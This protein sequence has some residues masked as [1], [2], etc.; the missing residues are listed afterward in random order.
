MH[1]WNPDLMKTIYPRQRALYIP[2]Y[3]SGA[4]AQH[5]PDQN[6]GLLSLGFGQT[7][8]MAAEMG[9]SE[10][11]QKMLNYA[12]RN[13]RGVWEE[14]SYYSPRNDD[15]TPDEHGNS[16]GVGSWTGNVLIALARLHRGDGF[17]KLYKKPWTPSDL[18]APEITDVDELTMS[19]KQA[20]YDASKKVLIVTISDGPVK[21]KTG[22]FVVRRMPAGHVYGV[23]SDGVVDLSASVQKKPDGS[24][25]VSTSLDKSH[26]FVILSE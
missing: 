22:S 7:A 16:H 12:D 18:Q 20:Y 17:L 8:F 25:L 9:D 14:G 2:Y 21:A 6:K 19:V 1:A 23:T 24:L 10:L 5:V 3:L 4:W 26:S 15:Y 13:F 11:R